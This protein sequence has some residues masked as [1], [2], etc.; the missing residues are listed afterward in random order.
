MPAMERQLATVATAAA[1][2][3]RMVPAETAVTQATVA[4]EAT[5]ETRNLASVVLSGKSAAEAVTVEILAQRESVAQ[6]VL[7]RAL[8]LHLVSLVPKLT[9]ATAETAVLEAHQIFQ[10]WPVATA[11]PVE[12]AE[13]QP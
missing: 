9:V 5:E 11:V 2:A 1:A 4:S 7:V 10:V 3:E 13:Q 8:L 6:R 12:T